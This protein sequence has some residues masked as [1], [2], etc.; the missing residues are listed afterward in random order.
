MTTIRHVVEGE[1]FDS[2]GDVLLSGCLIL[3]I[4]YVFGQC[5]RAYLSRRR[6]DGQE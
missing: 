6:S 1:I 2:V 4:A 5:A 3:S